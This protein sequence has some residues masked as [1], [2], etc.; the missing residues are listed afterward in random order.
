MFVDFYSL[1]SDSR[2][3][4]Y[5]T[6]RSI[7]DS[8]SEFIQNYLTQAIE[9][10]AAHG[11][12]LTAS[13]KISH[14]RFILI[15]L[16]QSLNEASGCSI[17]ASTHWFKELGNLLGI[18]F[19]DRSIAVLDKDNIKSI[20]VF[21]VKKSIQDGIINPDSVIFNNIGV[22]TLSDLDKNWRISAENSPSIRRFFNLVSS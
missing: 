10:W 7:S 3:W 18:D 21:Q 14:Q 2:I 15:G 11:A 20:S 5:Q 6:D 19:F 8:E 16:N 17:D 4:I 1:P 9:K 13:F 12:P 22:Q